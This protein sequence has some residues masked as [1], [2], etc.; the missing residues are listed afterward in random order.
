MSLF[1]PPRT[2]VCHG[3]CYITVDDVN[4]ALMVGGPYPPA[5]HHAAAAT[6]PE[7]HFSQIVPE[8]TLSQSALHDL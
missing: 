1:I 6:T 5:L 4:Y 3:Y 8:D 2:K 7:Y